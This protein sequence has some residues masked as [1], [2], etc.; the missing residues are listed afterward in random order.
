M[1][2]QNFSGST[3]HHGVDVV[4]Q[5]E[6]DIVGESL[7]RFDGWVGACT[8]GDHRDLPAYG[9]DMLGQNVTQDFQIAL[10][11]SH[12]ARECE[13]QR[14][15]TD[16]TVAVD[17]QDAA[18]LEGDV[19]SAVHGVAA[20]IGA[21]KAFGVDRVGAIGCWPIGQSQFVCEPVAFGIKYRQPSVDPSRQ[22]PCPRPQ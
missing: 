5:D 17:D 9:G 2:A 11:S 1:L 18:T 13:Q 14:A 16:G 22:S 4:Y 20:V 8:A 12:P 10:D 7:A 6:P 19:Y 15:F 3:V 21:G